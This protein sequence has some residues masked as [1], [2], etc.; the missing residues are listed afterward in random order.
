MFQGMHFCFIQMDT[1]GNTAKKRK[2]GFQASYSM[3]KLRTSVILSKTESCP[4]QG[5]NTLNC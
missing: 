2:K 5:G 4:K 1:T 3:T